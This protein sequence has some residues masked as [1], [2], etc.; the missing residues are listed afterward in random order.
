MAALLFEE[1][2]FRDCSRQTNKREPS[3]NDVQASKVIQLIKSHQKKKRAQAKCVRC[4]KR[5]IERTMQ[6]WC[7]TNYVACLSK[8]FQAALA[9][10][11]H[12]NDQ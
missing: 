3:P 5:G 10:N 9:K 7:S 2:G 1:I 12:K 8:Y 4:M 6:C 11:R